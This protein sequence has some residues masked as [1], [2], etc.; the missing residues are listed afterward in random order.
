MLQE[1]MTNEEQNRRK[2]DEIIGRL[3]RAHGSG[4][5]AR[6]RRRHSLP[7]SISD[8]N[9][10]P[11]TAGLGFVAPKQRIKP[12]IVHV[13]KART[14]T[15]LGIVKFYP[16]ETSKYIDPSKQTAVSRRATRNISDTYDDGFPVCSLEP[17]QSD[18][19]LLHLQ[20]DCDPTLKCLVNE[21]PITPL[22]V[23]LSDLGPKRELVWNP[24][25]EPL[26]DYLSV[27]SPLKVWRPCQWLVVNC[28][29]PKKSDVFDNLVLNCNVTPIKNIF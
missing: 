28:P 11:E 12:T 3:V 6:K 27:V 22:E 29:S 4:V 17:S 15:S 2:V 16:N 21:R 7:L 24:K 9:N 10:K 19:D 26:A 25:H 20:L 13:H 8:N 18:D 23:R 5:S 1:S 14:A